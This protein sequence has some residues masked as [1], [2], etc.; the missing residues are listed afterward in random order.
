MRSIVLGSVRSMG[1]PRGAEV[2]VRSWPAG[3]IGYCFPAIVVADDAS[4]TALFQPAGTVCK[5][6]GGARGGP[7]GRSLLEWDGTHRDVAVARTTVHLHLAGDPFWVI[8]G[9]DD[10][11]PAGWYINLAT[12]W[13]RFALGFDTE[14]HALDVVVADDRSSWRWKDEDELAWLVQRGAYSDEQADAIRRNGEA[15]VAHL[16]R[17]EP[18]FDDESWSSLSVDTAWPRPSFAQGWDVLPRGQ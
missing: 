9:W 11:G 6:R 1:W 4:R 5:R 8:R 14:D 3:V 15:A 7:Q 16:E 17:R 18:P 13:T 2:V 12:S 10:C